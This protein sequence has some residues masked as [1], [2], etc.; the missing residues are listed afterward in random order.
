M[1]PTSA[2]ITS[3]SSLPETQ[4]KG[5]FLHFREEAL[6]PHLEEMDESN[7]ALSIGDI[8][9]VA[10]TPSGMLEIPKFITTLVPADPNVTIIE[11]EA[12]KHY[13]AILQERNGNR[14]LKTINLLS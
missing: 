2:M 1:N 4:L 5:Q 13:I 3:K 11:F 14:E 9:D 12:F 6:V 10:G 7:T 8:K